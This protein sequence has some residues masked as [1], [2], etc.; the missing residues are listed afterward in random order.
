MALT[1]YLSRPDRHLFLAGT[2]TF[3]TGDALPFSGDQVLSFSLSEGSSSG[4]LLG[5]AFA[6][7]CTLTLNNAD[8]SFTL[9]HTPYGAQVTV[10]LC[11]ENESAPL[12]TFTVTKVVKRE[13]D[14]RLTLS[15]TDALGTAFEGVFE[16]SFTYPRTLRQ[17]AQGIA[18][19]AGFSLLNN[20][21]PN[22]A[23]SIPEKPDWG[24]ITLRQALAFVACAAG[25]FA[26]IDRQG[27]LVMRPVNPSMD[28]FVISPAHTLA[29]EYG[30]ASFG[31]VQALT[32]TPKGAKRD[33]PPLIVADSGAAP[34]GQN[35]FAI[36]G[37]PLF[38][39][40]G[41]H[42]QSLARALLNALRGLTQVKAKITWRGD[43]DLRLGDRVRLTDASGMS[44]DTLVTGQTLSFSRGFSM[45]SDCA[46][47][48]AASA[49]GKIFTPSGALNAA[50]LDGSVD[51]VLIQ[52][53]TLAAS[54][55]ISGSITAQQLA[56]NSITAQ[57][58]SA[59]SVTAGKLAASSVT[60]DAIAAD[61]IES[62]HLSAAALNALYASIAQA[63]IDW[64]N[65]TTLRAVMADIAHASL[66]VGDIDWARIKDLT[67]NR[68]VIT[69]G[70]AGELY[71]AQLA[72]TEANL[73]SLTVGEL[74]VRGEDGGFYALTVDEEG[75]V[76]T[77]RKQIANG[78]VQD[79]SIHGGEKLIEGSVTAQTLNAQDIF[80]DSAIIRQLIAANLDVDTLFARDAMISRLNAVDITGNESIRLF[81]QTQEAM[82]AYIRVTENGL[83]IGREGDSAR[84][85]ADNRTLD[86]TNVKT[87]R[88]GIA[89][90][91][92]TE[93]EWIWTASKTGIGLKYIG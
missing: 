31:P 91:M 87:E 54:S 55:L 57:Q 4:Q 18:A 65:I 19:Q 64:A 23:F 61:A 26:Q 77:Q 88:L 5:G 27:R 93:E 20:D 52:D 7:T 35:S 38:P 76:I 39:F 51:G 81:V 71:I 25:C 50:Q 56:A 22:A 15:G 10:R 43:P 8:G 6:A 46:A 21:F 40:A 34:N 68:A 82:S 12:I 30:E 29:R 24:E 14:P 47:P 13:N 53:G 85:Q 32:I 79:R 92:D 78:D 74:V 17:L 59:G 1:S 28:P 49:V 44:T 67:S 42:T 63:D 33:T 89:Q 70:E 2:M 9:G 84:F 69:Q 11:E 86:V 3:L 66:S 58:L 41:A 75:Q 60:A 45:Q 37:N 80:G 36:S 48:G 16:D 72:V 73:L 83:E 90:A 62:R